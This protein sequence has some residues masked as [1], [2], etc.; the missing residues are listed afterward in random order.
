MASRLSSFDLP[1]SITSSLLKSP[2]E[3]VPPTD[4]LER[5]FS[6]LKFAQQKAVERSR[7]AGED[8]RTIAE[9]MRRMAEKEKGKSKAVDKVKRERDCAYVSVI[10]VA[11]S[12]YPYICPFT[13]LYHSSG[14][15][16]QLFNCKTTIGYYKYGLPF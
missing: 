5:L 2:P 1:P 15:N 9:S 12:N 10:F 3:A 13:Y 11:V 8:L 6:E 16:H 7:K 14:S 4:E